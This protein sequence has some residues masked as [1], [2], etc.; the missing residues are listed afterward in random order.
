MIVNNFK[1]LIKRFIFKSKKIDDFW[2]QTLEVKR[3]HDR[4]KIFDSYVVNKKVLH[5]GCTDYPI[6]N[7][8]NNL[9]LK[10]SKICKKLHGF[11][12]DIKGLEL[13]RTYYNG[14]YF[15]SFDQITEKYDTVLIPETI[16]HVDNIKDFLENIYRIDSK[17]FIISGP[18]CFNSHFSHGFKK[19]SGKLFEEVVHPDHNCW[20]SP[21]TLKN[22]IKKYTNLKINDIYLSN[23]D[24]MVI[25]ICEKEQ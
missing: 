14:K 21:Y 13:L 1:S 15:S 8:N 7:P 19:N 25:C 17:Y 4:L 16:E 6:F 11:D 3:N 2:V 24:L 22:T 5:F 23:H 18:N 20:F 9:H 12:I 10:L